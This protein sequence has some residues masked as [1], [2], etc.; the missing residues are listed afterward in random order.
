V[1]RSWLFLH[2]EFSLTGHNSVPLQMFS[3]VAISPAN[4]GSREPQ[5]LP[6]TELPRRV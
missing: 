2:H 3:D 4:V 6:E 1:Y 5:F